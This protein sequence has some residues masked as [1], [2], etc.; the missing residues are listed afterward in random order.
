MRRCGCDVCSGSLLFGRF[1]SK[2]PTHPLLPGYIASKREFLPIEEKPS[3]SVSEKTAVETKQQAGGK[4][5]KNR[6]SKL[7]EK[8]S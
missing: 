7:A 5:K 1:K 6:K 2:I 8:K 3:T 4:E